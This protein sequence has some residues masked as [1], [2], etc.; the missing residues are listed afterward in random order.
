MT[1]DILRLIF[2][3]IVNEKSFKQTVL[4]SL[5]SIQD[6]SEAEQLKNLQTV[7]SDNAAPNSAKRR[8]EHRALEKA[9]ERV[10][11]AL[12]TGRTLRPKR[13]RTFDSS[14]EREEIE[15]EETRDDKIILDTESDEVPREIP[16]Q[17]NMSGRKPNNI[18]K[19]QELIAKAVQIQCHSVEN[20][21]INFWF[22][23]SFFQLWHLRKGENKRIRNLMQYHRHRSIIC[24]KNYLDLMKATLKLLKNTWKI[25]LTN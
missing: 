2:C 16:R 8:L 1:C 10:V 14:P 13:R 18:Y 22:K 24:L 5:K 20:L 12:S 21:I 4:N 25:K 3:M 7:F 19:N 6:Y 23:I 17:R 15:P 9:T 11:E